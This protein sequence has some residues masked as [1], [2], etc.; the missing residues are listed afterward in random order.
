MRRFFSSDIQGDH[1]F[2]DDEESRHLK[3]VLRAKIGDEIEVVNGE[4]DLY[5][6]EILELG[7]KSSELRI[8]ERSTA[9]ENSNSL[10]IA[11]AP[12]KNIN[13]WEW[14]LEK[15]SEIGIARISPIICDNSERKHLKTDRQLRILKEAMKQSKQLHL[16]K[17]DELQSFKQF[18]QEAEAT[19]KFI[20]HCYG[21]E[22]VQL[23]SLHQKGIKS[24]ILIGPE[25]DFSLDEVSMAE[26]K[27]FKAVSLGESRLR[28]ET[29]AIVACHTINLLDA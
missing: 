2:L 3:Q 23:K 9:A 5:V 28:T 10:W 27:G 21:G 1:I 4:G 20:A 7:K 24:L 12:T 25:G 14:F 16:P 13:R 29:A 17:L 19:E 22:K 15:A 8:K 26:N 11:V 18:I 6:S